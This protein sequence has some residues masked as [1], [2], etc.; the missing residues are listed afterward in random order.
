MFHF[1]PAMKFWWPPIA[2]GAVS[3]VGIAA[4]FRRRIV[5]LALV[6]WLLGTFV[7]ILLISIAQSLFLDRI[8]LDA[9]FPLYLLIGIGITWL[10]RRPAHVLPLLALAIAMVSVSVATLRPIYASESQP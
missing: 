5:V 2:S 10:G 1:L 7:T 8:L 9:T 4:V 3:V 6:A